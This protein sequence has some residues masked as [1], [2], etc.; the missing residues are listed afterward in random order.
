MK[1]MHAID[2]IKNVNKTEKTE[3]MIDKNIYCFIVDKSA[4]KK[5]I[6]E[7]LEM[8]YGEEVLSVNKVVN[9]SKR[10]V[11]SRKFAMKKKYNMGFQ[12]KAYVRFKS[13]IDVTGG[14]KGDIQS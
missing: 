11:I 4:D 10:K 12:V 13:K 1:K 9:L 3:S 14:F 6:K 7:T 8:L 2:L 5:T